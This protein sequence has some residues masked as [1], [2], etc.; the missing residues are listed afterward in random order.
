MRNLPSL[1]TIKIGEIGR[2]SRN[3]YY[4]SFVIKDLP[5]LNSITLGNYA[6]NHSLSTVIS[7]LP[8]LNS[9]QLGEWTL[10]GKDDN[11]CSLIMENLPN[12]TSITSDGN[13]FRYPC[14]VTLS[15]IP[16]LKTVDLPDSFQYVESKSIT[17][18]CMNM[19]EWIDV[20][21]ILANLI[22]INNRL[23]IFLFFRLIASIWNESYCQFRYFFDYWTYLMPSWIL[24]IDRDSI[25][26]SGYW[27][28]TNILFNNTVF[29]IDIWNRE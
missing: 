9:I 24:L 14:S 25:N 23:S 26:K 1:S 20:S 2:G 18:I 3:F 17:S 15:N 27:I 12:L 7:S 29:H 8:N 22:W 4:S 6:F 10:Q 19:N 13:S 16:N 11:D 21:T 28:Y 5:H